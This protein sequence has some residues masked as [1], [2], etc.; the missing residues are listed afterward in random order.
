MTMDS[1]RGPIQTVTLLLTQL[2]S[3]RKFAYFSEAPF[4]HV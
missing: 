3:L 2:V 4:P 1:I